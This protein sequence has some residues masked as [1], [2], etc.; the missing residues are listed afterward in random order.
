M[1]AFP[2]WNLDIR[3]LSSFFSENLDPQ[4]VLFE[5]CPVGIVAIHLAL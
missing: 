4:V 5:C 2:E 1:L 3:L